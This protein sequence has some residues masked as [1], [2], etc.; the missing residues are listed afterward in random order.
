MNYKYLELTKRI[1]AIAHAGL[2]YADNGFDQERYQ[3]LSEISLQ[4]MQEFS[5]TDIAIIADLFKHKKDYPTPKVDIRAV[6][7]Q[8]DQLLMVREKVD[9][10]WALP[11]GWADVGYTPA[12]VVVK[13]VREEA[14]LDVS[15]VKVLAILDKKCHPHPPQPFYI[16]KIFILCDVLGG[17]ISA[18]VETSDVAFFSQKA[19]PPL[20]ED[21][22]TMSQID[23]LFSLKENSDAAVIFD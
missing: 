13:E 17:V 20:S 21:R 12:E 23:M 8:D 3:E 16:Y 9:G 4:L 22:N 19:I 18:G 15:A 2:T 14:G 7:F 1:Q 5:N 6:I 11:G 10:C